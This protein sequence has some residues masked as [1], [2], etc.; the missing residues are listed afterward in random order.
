MQEILGDSQPSVEGILWLLAQLMAPFLPSAPPCRFEAGNLLTNP[1]WFFH[2]SLLHRRGTGSLLSQQ[3]HR[4]CS[5]KI[6]GSG[7]PGRD[8]QVCNPSPGSAAAF[9]AYKHPHEQQPQNWGGTSLEASQG[10]TPPEGS[11]GPAMSSP[12]TRWGLAPGTTIPEE[13]PAF[14]TSSPA[15]WE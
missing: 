3:C 15:P 10:P 4:N 6:L 9:I 12:G 13:F 14:Q 8:G 5:L 2:L 11:P 7:S 1:V